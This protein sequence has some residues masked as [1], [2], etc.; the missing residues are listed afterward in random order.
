MASGHPLMRR[1][2]WEVGP[3]GAVG[4]YLI[5]FAGHLPGLANMVADA[6]NNLE[7]LCELCTRARHGTRPNHAVVR[8]LPN[9]ALVRRLPW[10]CN[11]AWLG[12]AP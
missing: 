12:R 11:K 2:A 9:H 3:D 5:D 1:I 8:R 6:L 7:A 10:A 4:V